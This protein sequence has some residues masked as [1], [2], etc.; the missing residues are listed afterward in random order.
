MQLVYIKVEISEKYISISMA[1]HC[2]MAHL[3]VL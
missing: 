3:L 2:I 1:A